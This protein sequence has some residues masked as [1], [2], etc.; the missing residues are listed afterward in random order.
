[1]TIFW[2][3]WRY[4][5]ICRRF[6]A[7]PNYWKGF[8]IIGCCQVFHYFAFI[9][10]FIIMI[11]SINRSFCLRHY[12]QNGLSY[13]GEET[14]PKLCLKRRQANSGVRSFGTNKYQLSHR[15]TSVK[16]PLIYNI[17][18]TLLLQ[19][20][21]VAWHACSIRPIFFFLLSYHV[22]QWLRQA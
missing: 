7:C 20:L 3:L 6:T 17:F 10:L 9:V 18:C 2:Y 13:L 1:M 15:I 19:I 22:Y 5:I 11:D 4:H 8:K 21:C 14:W 12:V 16:T